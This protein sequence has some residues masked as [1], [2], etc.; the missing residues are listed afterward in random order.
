M[1]ALTK[2]IRSCRQETLAV[3]LEEG[4]NL[5]IHCSTTAFETV[6]KVIGSQI[7]NSSTLEY[8]SNEDLKGNIYSEVVKVKEKSN[9][10]RR[11]KRDLFTVNIYRTTSSLLINGPQVQKFIQEILPAI[12]T[13]AQHNGTVI[14][15][16]Q[17]AVLQQ[18]RKEQ[19]R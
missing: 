3:K 18:M 2:K 8:L 11:N 10:T 12:Q 19:I 4:N 16:Q 1:V 13:W 17:P 7:E 6:R 15:I 5:R 14:R 9:T